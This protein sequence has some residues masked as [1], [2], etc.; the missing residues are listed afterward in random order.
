M[1][2]STDLDQA[3]IDW[4]QA[5]V[6]LAALCQPGLHVFWDTA[7]AGSTKFVLVSLVDEHDEP[8]FEGR[9]FEDTLYLVKAVAREPASAATIKAAAAR[10]DVLLNPQRPMRPATITIAGYRL[11][12]TRRES[13]VR[14]TEVDDVDTSIR[15]QHRGGRYQVVAAPVAA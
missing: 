4:L 8:V 9:A 7:P 1:S 13:R 10:I 6:P 3:L 2:D 11:L 15:W 14:M 12:L 5:D